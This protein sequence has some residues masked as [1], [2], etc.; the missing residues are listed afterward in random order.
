MVKKKQE[1]S[2]R[3]KSQ[4]GITTMNVSQGQCW[5]ET[6]K[7]A[8]T[9]QKTGFLVKDGATPNPMSMSTL[10]LESTTSAEIPL[11]L[12]PA[13]CSATPPTLLKDT[14]SVPFPFAHC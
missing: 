8:L 13:K 11:N 14:S 4:K 5:A 10:M 12:P 6:T 9:P 1:T 2:P 3:R 7:E